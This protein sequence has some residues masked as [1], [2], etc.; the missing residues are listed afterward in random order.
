MQDVSKVQRFTQMYQLFD[1]TAQCVA[2]PIILDKSAASVIRM[3]NGVLANKDILPGQY[4]EQFTMLLVGQQDD[5]TGAIEASDPPQT[6][7]TGQQWL[8]TQ[9]R[10]EQVSAPAV[11]L[12]SPDRPS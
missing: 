2:G 10:G 12:R 1:L 6:I 3:F 5:E 8:E 9:N 4:P 11:V 7:A